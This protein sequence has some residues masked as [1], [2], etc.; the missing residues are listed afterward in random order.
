MAMRRTILRWLLPSLAF[1]LLGVPACYDDVRYPPRARS[2]AENT[3]EDR[4]PFEEATCLP[5]ELGAGIWTELQWDAATGDLTLDLY[6]APPGLDASVLIEDV[7]TQAL[8][9]V[10][11]YYDVDL[12][13]GLDCPERLHQRLRARLPLDRLRQT[14]A[15]AVTLGADAPDPTNVVVQDVAGDLFAEPLSRDADYLL[16]LAPL[17]AARQSAEGVLT[18]QW[19]TAAPDCTT[20]HS[21]LLVRPADEV[22]PLLT[23]VYQVRVGCAPEDVWRTEEVDLETATPAEGSSDL[24]LL[25][26]ARDEPTL[27]FVPVR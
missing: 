19:H 5:E 3:F 9:R 18:V 10:V 13:A 1:S 14:M 25:G 7:G 27:L 11:F 20:A 15:V 12:T 4:V 24:V 17:H 26:R 21:R 16:R 22:Y 23:A 6:G 2:G 8:S